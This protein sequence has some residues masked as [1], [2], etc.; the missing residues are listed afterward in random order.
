VK[1]RQ[2]VYLAVRSE[3]VDPGIISERLRLMPDVVK[4]RGSRRAGPPPVPRT[5]LWRLN[6]GVESE[7]LPLGHHLDALL[8]RL[9]DSA[10]RLRQL[11]IDEEV[12]AVIQVVRRF[13]PG[14]EDRHVVEPGPPPGEVERL[15]G[16]H[17]LLGFSIE[18]ELLAYAA[19]AGIG[20]DFDEYGDE[21]Q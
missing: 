15:G 1:V 13:D 17:R 4:L 10:H 5:H 9:G 12:S 8:A 18:A 3:S 6:S 16:Q 7:D 20:F 19:V 2:Y 14:P 21:D 11:T